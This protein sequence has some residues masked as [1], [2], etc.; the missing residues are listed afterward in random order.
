MLVL[1]CIKDHQMLLRDIGIIETVIH[2]IIAPFDMDRRHLV[3]QLLNTHQ[4]SIFSHIDPSEPLVL[5]DELKRGDQGR[6]RSILTM[7]Y[8]LIRVFLIGRSSFEEQSELAKENQGHVLKVAG[9]TGLSL[10]ISHLPFGIG[11]TNMMTRL[12]CSNGGDFMDSLFNF[13]SRAGIIDVMIDMALKKTTSIVD[14]MNEKHRIKEGGR[15]FPKKRKSW[16]GDF[17]ADQQGDESHDER[18]YDS[19]SCFKLLSALCYTNQH[20]E[21]HH[22]PLHSPAPN[23]L[24]ENATAS[25]T[26]NRDYISEKLLDKDQC[27]LATRVSQN[28]QVEIKFRNDEWRSLYD[29]LYSQP[30]VAIYLESVLELVYSLSDGTTHTRTLDLTRRAVSKQVCLNCVEYVMLPC[31]IKAKFCD[32]LRG[33]ER[34][35]EIC[36]WDIND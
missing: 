32:I 6:L 1:T 26:Q 15:S 8:H 25:V 14:A 36:Q 24:K 27:L 10:F 21:Q 17:I 9:E 11:A 19:S 30:A 20:Q 28:N 34:K 4:Q 35:K 29:V 16:N 31:K 5:L 12:L 2:M 23:K 33:K 13:S 18:E 22:Q 3:R 7:C